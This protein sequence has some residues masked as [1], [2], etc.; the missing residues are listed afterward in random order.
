M[1][2]IFELSRLSR[3]HEVHVT[4]RVT[5]PLN[6]EVDKEHQSVL[7]LA[8]PH[9]VDVE[10]F[11]LIGT[12]K[13]LSDDSSC[14]MS[15]NVVLCIILLYFCTR[16]IEHYI[17]FLFLF[18][19]KCLVAMATAARPFFFFFFSSFFAHGWRINCFPPCSVSQTDLTSRTRCNSLAAK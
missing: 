3:P 1:L 14:R 16:F 4:L 11:I 12:N 19:S 17:L 15:L 18:V 5:K 13:I 2:V 8:A 7:Q 9:P 10:Y 6:P